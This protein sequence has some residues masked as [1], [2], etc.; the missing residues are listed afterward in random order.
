MKK[1]RLVAVGKL[2]ERYFADAFDEYA[3]RIGR[4]ADF[5]VVETRESR[6]ESVEEEA[7][8]ILAALSVTVFLFDIGGEQLSSEALAARLK[9]ALEHGG[10]TFVIGSSRGVSDRVRAAADVRVSFG[11]A[12]FPHRLFRVMAAE[13]IYRALA[14]NNN[15]PYHK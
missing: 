14:I 6:S 4:F 12:T 5:S 8:D 2:K 10:A 11:A 7:A 13:Q 15:L 9:T 3:R 1:L